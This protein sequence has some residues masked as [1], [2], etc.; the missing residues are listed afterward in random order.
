MRSGSSAPQC[1]RQSGAPV[2]A[3]EMGA[4]HPQCVEQADYV[5]Q[6]HRVW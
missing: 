6:Q 2:V 5:G 1:P 3:D 4:L